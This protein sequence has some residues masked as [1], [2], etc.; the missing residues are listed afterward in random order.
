MGVVKLT[1]A[2]SLYPRPETKEEGGANQSPG[3]R[4]TSWKVES[5]LWGR[6]EATEE[7]QLLLESHRKA[8]GRGS[9]ACFLPP[10]LRSPSSSSHWPNLAGSQLTLEPRNAAYR[11]HLPAIQ[12]R[13]EGK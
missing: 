7:T 13:S 9:G 1:T 11:G 2:R 12:S 4:T 3:A 10:T 5:C 8:E 6:A